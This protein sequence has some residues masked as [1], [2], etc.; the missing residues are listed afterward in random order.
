MGEIKKGI[1]KETELHDKDSFHAERFLH[2]N[3][4]NAKSIKAR[5]GFLY[6]AFPGAHKLVK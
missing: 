1:P 6:K 4:F 3:G 2:F 5:K